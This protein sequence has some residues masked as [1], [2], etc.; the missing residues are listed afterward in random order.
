MAFKYNMDKIFAD[1]EKQIRKQQE[2]KEN[3]PI[4]SPEDAPKTQE[5]APA[6]SK[7]TEDKHRR[8]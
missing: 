4:E 5:V 6:T 1:L 8:R 3:N 2:Q 7:T